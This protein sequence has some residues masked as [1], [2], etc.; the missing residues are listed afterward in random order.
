MFFEVNNF[1]LF[2]CFFSKKKRRKKT[3]KKWY[4]KKK[5]VSFF[6]KCNFTDNNVLNITKMFW[7]HVL[8]INLVKKKFRSCGKIRHKNIQILRFFKTAG[9]CFQF[10]FWKT[11]NL[12][13]G[14]DA[15]FFKIAFFVSFKKLLIFLVY[16][17]F[18]KGEPPFPCFLIFFPT[19]FFLLLLK[20]N[21]FQ[22]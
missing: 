14:V 1:S 16:N 11:C 7:G 13:N 8:R 21:T 22:K 12:R 5:G 4:R 20:N 6:F 19:S 18:T 3:K 10:F 15:K 2:K 9:C 17:V